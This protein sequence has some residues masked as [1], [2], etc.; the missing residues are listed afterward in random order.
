[1]ARLGRRQN[2]PFKVTCLDY[3]VPFVAD[4][5]ITSEQLKKYSSTR[6]FAPIEEAL[7]DIPK[8]EQPLIV[9]VVPMLPQ[10]DVYRPHLDN[11]TTVSLVFR[12]HVRSFPNDASLNSQVTPGKVGSEYIPKSVSEELDYSLIDETV[13]V[14]LERSGGRGGDLP[15]PHSPLAGWQD[16]LIRLNVQRAMT[17]SGKETANE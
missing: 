11:P 10:A 16:T 7:K 17:A 3:L 5:V 15:L 12:M 8:D 9:E 6:D 13:R 14:I 4:D 1:M 2:K